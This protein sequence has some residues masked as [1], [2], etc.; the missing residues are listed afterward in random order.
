MT[1]PL[2][3]EAEA[4]RFLLVTVGVAAAVVLASVLG[5]PWSGTAVAVL[6]IGGVIW[7]YARSG[8]KPPPSRTTARPARSR[9]PRRQPLP[10]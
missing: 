2:R 5:G 6:L 8:Q 9:G 10:P 3:T 1:N 4:Y 7:V